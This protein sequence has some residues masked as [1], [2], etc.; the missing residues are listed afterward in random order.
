MADACML[1]S[2]RETVSLSPQFSIYE[3]NTWVWLAGL[4]EMLGHPV[5]LSSVPASEWDAIAAKGFDVVW[6]MGVWERSPAGKAIADRSANLLTEFRRCLPNVRAE[7]NVGSAYCIRRYVADPHLGGPE[8]LAI[9]RRQL[10]QRGLRLLLDFVP[11]HVAPDAQAIVEHPERFVQGTAA[12]LAAH[13]G[14][15]LAIGDKVF[16]CGRDPYFP[17]WPDVVQVNA[18]NPGHRESTIQTLLAI[19]EQC[20]GVRCDMAM[21]LI[22]GIFA[23]TWGSQAGNPPSEEYWPAVI[24]AVHRSAPAFLFLAEAYWDLEWTLQQE[25]FAFCYDKRLYDLVV[26]GDAEGVQRHLGAT[27][28]YQHKLVRFIENHDEPRVAALFSPRKA[29]AAAI[30]MATV[31]GAKL[32]HE[33]QL[34]GRRVRLPVF[35]GRRPDELKDSAVA[36]FYSRLLA[37]IKA[38]V[39][40][41]GEWALCTCSGWLDNQTFQKLGAWCW[42]ASEDRRLVV[43]N[44][45]ER[46]AQGRVRLPW[47]D[48]QVK[49]W[50]LAD[51]LSEAS[52]DRE[53][54]EMQSEG[55][56]VALEAWAGQILSVTPL[57]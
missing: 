57:A 12:D 54:S 7:D 27:L 4:G 45:S 5:D 34:E 53:G 3:I 36:A 49:R 38:A 30:L 51:A 47:K 9:A 14:S 37:T 41:E 29:M 16:A 52:Y 19:A 2:V 11:N 6:L 20:D 35:L 1:R 21:L 33:G 22:N 44:L 50:R 23:R 43:V 10:A 17:P 15:Y 40:R 46:P 48:L 31:P 25:G 39:F 24:N 8:G 26:H 18:F 56:Y 42:T 28:V 13:P 55:L 32:F